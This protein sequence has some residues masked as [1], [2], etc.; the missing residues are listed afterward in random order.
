MKVTFYNKSNRDL[1]VYK[2]IT[3]IETTR[4]IYILHKGENRGIS[5]RRKYNV[6]LEVNE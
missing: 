2:D 6:L 4:Y 3:K 5:V 1:M